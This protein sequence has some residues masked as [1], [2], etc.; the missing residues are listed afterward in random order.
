MSEKP[1]AVVIGAGVGGLA[2]AACLAQTQKYDVTVYDRMSFAGGRFTQHDHDGFQIPTGAVHMIPHGRRGPFAKLLLGK[3]ISGGLD[4]GRHGVEFLPTTKFACRMKDGKLQEAN[5]VYGILPWFSVR[6]TL[7]LPRLLLT[8]ANHPWGDETEDG[9]TWMSKRFS[10]EFVD[11][12]DAFANFA[13]S[14]RF[15]QMPASTVVKMLQN[16]FWSDRPA[17]PKG[18]CKGVINGLR[19]DLRENGARVKLSNEVTEILPGDAE[20]S[21]KGNRFCI[22]V[23]RRG[24]QEGIW[25][26]ADSIIHNGGH[27][28]LLAALSDDF[29]VAAGVREQ[30]RN[31]QAVGGIGFVFALDDDIPHRSSGVTMLPNLERV[32]GYVLPTFSEP[33]LAPEGKHMMITHQ[34][35]PDPSVKSEI[36]KGREDLHDAIP[37]LAD[38]GEELCVH[39]YHRN[40]PCNR[41]P[42]GAE[43]PSDIGVEGVRLVGDGVKGHGWMMVEGIAA[44]VPEA[45]ASVSGA[46][47][48]R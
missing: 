25:V 39:T 5:S 21:T 43:L 8:R 27:P 9:R 34:H 14:L 19:A 22:G 37:W 7:N 33:S 3:K 28:N 11:F 30:V 45:V 10:E 44:N 20:E 41:A 18:G 42:Q 46:M 4:L 31:T 6:D 23:R 48:A 35:V 26:G 16:S 47:D 38:H 40:W 32:G 17:V 36:D 2:S 1:K 15:D 13:I 12:V 24:R 29:E